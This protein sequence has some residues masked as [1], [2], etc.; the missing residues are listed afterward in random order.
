M[1][2]ENYYIFQGSDWSGK[3]K[4]GKLYS[5]SVVLLGRPFFIAS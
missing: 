3:D 5:M 2:V 4:H 1:S